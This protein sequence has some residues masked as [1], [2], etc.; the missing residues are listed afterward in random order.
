MHITKCSS[1]CAQLQLPQLL[2]LNV[3]KK[4][5]HTKTHIK[6][7]FNKMDPKTSQNIG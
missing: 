5:Q 2:L 3:W 1:Q 7:E 6:C 4:T